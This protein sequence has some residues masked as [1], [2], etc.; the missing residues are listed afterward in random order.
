[1]NYGALKPYTALVLAPPHQRQEELLSDW[2][3]F[4]HLLKKNKL[5]GTPVTT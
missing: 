2:I 1:M 5:S 3:F 4:D